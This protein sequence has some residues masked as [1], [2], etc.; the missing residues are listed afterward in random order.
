MADDNPFAEVYSDYK[1]SPTKKDEPF[2]DVYAGYR[3]GPTIGQQALDVIKQVPSGLLTGTEAVATFPAQAAS[4]VGG[5]VKPLLPELET[6][7][8][9]ANRAKLRELIEKQRGGGIAG[10]LP[11]PTTTAGRYARTAAEFVPSA[12]GGARATQFSVPRAGAIGAGAGAASEAAG[13]A[14]EGTGW[15]T[16]A[17]VGAA[18]LTG[19]LAGKVAETRAARTLPAQIR[20]QVEAAGDRGFDQFR[21]SGFSF[22]PTAA[23][24]YSQVLK[25]NL[26]Q[27]GFTRNT[28]GPV[29][30]ILDD[31]ERNPFTTPQE[32]QA[33]YKELGRV[34]KREPE[35]AQAARI[36]Q[37]RLLTFAENP[38]PWLVTG[39]DPAAG[40][41]LLREAN[42]NWAA[43]KRAE[44]LDQRIN[45]AELKAGSTYSGLNLENQLRQRVGAL[46]QPERLGGMRGATPAERQAFIN[47]AEGS[48]LQ[49]I[50]RYAGKYLGGGG[51]LGA[52]AA[53]S[54][55][56][57]AG[58][59]FG[60][61]PLTYGGATTLA[62]LGLTR[63]GNAAALRRARELELMLMRRAPAAP[64]TM[65]GL[66][67][68]LPG[69]LTP[70]L[71]QSLG[72][73]YTSEGYPYYQAGTE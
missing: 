31:I 30:T 33:R 52:L 68:L 9:E 21:A 2:A 18:L 59:Y 29:W 4:F 56:A 70:G 53:G 44:L 63:F 36:A 49:N 69:S 64:D 66:R 57:G 72:E 37:E 15:E 55:G 47:F 27:E 28:A 51:G 39:G 14:T 58:A 6:P 43:A 65:P 61:D 7:E 34:S 3:P 13:Q 35:Q 12:V 50:G 54:A 23:P 24:T 60:L 41:A 1:S 45:T 71:L 10:M 17:R 25:Q 42:A 19:G 8:Q 40:T 67:S 20:Q 46:G 22:D 11:E 62:G 48:A 38:A 73:R 16:P 5:L 32:M 26:A